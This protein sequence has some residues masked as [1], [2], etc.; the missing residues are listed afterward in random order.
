M[1]LQLVI[2]KESADFVL[3][4]GPLS[5]NEFSISL[6]VDADSHVPVPEG[7]TDGDIL[8][9]LDGK[10][11]YATPGN[12]IGKSLWQG[13]QSEYDALTTKDPNT[14]YLITS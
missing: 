5:Q 7:K 12:M 4:I 8:R 14:L 13:T 10:L 6:T 9:V 1:S 2:I 3:N 11:V